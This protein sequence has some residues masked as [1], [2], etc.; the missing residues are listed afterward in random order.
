MSFKTIKGIYWITFLLSIVV[1]PL[2]IGLVLVV[3]GGIILPILILHLI[4][5]IQLHKLE[6]HKRTVLLSAINL[7]AFTLIRPDGVHVFNANGISSVLKIFGIRAGYSYEYEDYCVLI[8]IIL[9]IVQI[10]LEIR[11]NALRIRK[12]SNNLKNQQTSY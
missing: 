4:I 12:G 10:F 8:S 9:I 3:F 5:G 6:K 7:L 11:L 1:L 2:N